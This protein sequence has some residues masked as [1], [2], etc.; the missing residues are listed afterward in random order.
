MINEGV[1]FV[2]KL[3]DYMSSS[4]PKVGSAAQSAFAK[5]D[6]STR[7]TQKNLD[8][9]GRSVKTLERAM[10]MLERKRDLHIDTKD[11]DEANRKIRLLDNRINHLKNRGGIMQPTVG[12][13]RSITGG[14]MG[15]G[16]SI[17]R[18]AG[19]AAMLGVTAGAVGAVGYSANAGLQGGAQRMSFETM[20]GNQAGG[21][22][23]KDITKFA[24]D[25]IFG[26]EL[27]KN[28]Q[29]QLAFGAEAK[30]VMPTLRMLGD[31][32]MGDTERLKSLNLAYSQSRSAGKLMGQ[33]LLQFVNAGFNPLQ[34]MSEQTGKSMAKL[35]EEMSEGKISFDKVKGAFIAATSAGGK[36]YKMT[37]RIAETPFGKREALRGQIQGLG[38]EIGEALAPAI[39]ELIDKYANPAVEYIGKE[40]IPKV[41]GIVNGAMDMIDSYAPILERMLDTGG[42]LIRPVVDLLSSDEI[43]GLSQELLGL[44]ADIGESLVPAVE[45]L[46]DVMK[47]IAALLRPVVGAL[48]FIVGAAKI[49]IG[50]KD[51]ADNASNWAERQRADKEKLKGIF[52]QPWGQGYSDTSSRKLPM[53]LAEVAQKIKAP[54]Q[55]AALFGNNNLAQTSTTAGKKTVGAAFDAVANGAGTAGS[56]STS[57]ITGGGKRVLNININASPFTI[58][59]MD[60][61]ARAGGLQGVDE[62]ER[63][64]NEWFLRLLNAG[65]AQI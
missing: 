45:A 33:D 8:V 27:Y 36:F 58:N 13:T 15:F 17:R 43:S 1:Q 7:K 55:P 14:G 12:G 11:I 54:N 39:G 61:A 5:V 63:R 32:S 10:R 23:Y 57:P 28:A 6:N 9:T 18:M 44:S 42:K 49:D 4:L 16:S 41:S 47:P 53:T 26:N 48:R 37:D 35:R 20:A 38:L 2:L 50:I 60:V 40:I 19:M 24:Q 65:A 34:Q 25:S 29:T 62:M 56:K 59:K 3:K 21:K 46:T 31:I 30:E 64:F 52:D 22:L 51:A